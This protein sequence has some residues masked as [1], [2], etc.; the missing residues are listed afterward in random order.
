MKLQ[1]LGILRPD[2]VL[3][4]TS[5]T[6]SAKKFFGRIVKM[7]SLRYQCFKKNLKCVCCGIEGS[8]MQ[9]EFRKGDGRPHFNLYAKREGRL[10]LMT[11]DHILPKSRGGSDDMRNLR[12]MCSRCNQLSGNYATALR[13]LR[14]IQDGVQTVYTVY[15]GCKALDGFSTSYKGLEA[16]A[17]KWVADCYGWDD[18]LYDVQCSFRKALIKIIPHRPVNK[19]Y[20]NLSL[21]IKTIRR[22]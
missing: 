16:I 17:R 3:P 13:T 5:P 18:D 21:T 4:H 8:V 15:S 6:R 11:K 1:I 10:V 22:I 12:T 14:E 19:R 7:S 2:Q 9:L 20:G